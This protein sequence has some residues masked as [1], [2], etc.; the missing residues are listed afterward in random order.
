MWD[1][2]IRTFV[3]EA[4]ECWN[5]LVNAASVAWYHHVKVNIENKTAT[6]SDNK[7]WRFTME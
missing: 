6:G 3:R 2:N 4:N 7:I 1:F 5:N